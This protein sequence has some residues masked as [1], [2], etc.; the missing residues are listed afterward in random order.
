[1]DS[2][3][4]FIEENSILS[5]FAIGKKSLENPRFHCRVETV[6]QG[7]TGKQT[8]SHP[9]VSPAP[10]LSKGHLFVQRQRG[11]FGIAKWQAR[12]RVWIVQTN[13]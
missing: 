12:T 7:F 9:T 1:M 4:L 13:S 11:K 5:L 8:N 10:L 6:G 2:P 3:A